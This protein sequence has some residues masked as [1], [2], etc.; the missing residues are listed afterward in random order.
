MVHS[1]YHPQAQS[2]QGSVWMVHSGY[3]TLKHRPL[4]IVFGWCTV[5]IILKHSPL[6]IVFGWYAVDIIHLGIGL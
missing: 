5:D 4:R 3:P 1:G 6:R 2:S